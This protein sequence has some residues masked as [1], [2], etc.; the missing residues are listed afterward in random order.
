ML[1]A[2][3]VQSA[4][5]NAKRDAFLTCLEQQVAAAKTQ[6]IA[7][8]AFETAVREACAASANALKAELIAFDLKNKVPRKL[9]SEDAQLQVDDFLSTSVSQYKKAAAAPAK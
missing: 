2:V 3:L 5:I 4:P 9:A 1:V 7:G 8:D 6:K